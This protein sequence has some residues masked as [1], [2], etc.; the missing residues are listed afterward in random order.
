M[1]NETKISVAA[2]GFDRRPRSIYTIYYTCMKYVHNI[3]DFDYKR[4]AA[5]A[6]TYAIRAAAVEGQAGGM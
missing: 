5:V 3:D 4:H 6:L 1:P 2:N